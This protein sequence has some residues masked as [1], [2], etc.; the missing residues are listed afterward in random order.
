MMR[1]RGKEGHRRTGHRRG[2]LLGFWMVNDG[3]GMSGWSVDLR[4][5]R[6]R[7]LSLARHPIA[8]HTAV[9]GT[10]YGKTEKFIR[11]IE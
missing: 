11:K 3:I 10:R 2:N 7:P 4:E 8:Q 1:G 5:H 6:G 9:R